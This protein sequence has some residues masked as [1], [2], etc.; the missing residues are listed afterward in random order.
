[1]KP[2]LVGM[3]LLAGVALAAEPISEDPWQALLAAR[4]N[5]AGEVSYA[6]IIRDERVRLERVLADLAAKNVASLERDHAIAFWLNAYHAMV[7]DAVMH[8]ERPTTMPGRAR[9]FHWYHRH[10]GGY[11]LTLDDVRFILNGFASQDPRIHLAIYDGTRSSPRLAPEPY[12]ADRLDAQL[13]AAARRF[14]NDSRNFRVN[15]AIGRVALS[16]VFEWYR[17]DF[18]RESGTLAGF[19]LPYADNQA[20]RAAL[21][22]PV[23]GF[24]SLPF[25]W[26][27]DGATE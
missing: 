16:K 12:R 22:S 1:M 17:A 5:Q 3:L 24:E 4:V 21:L 8:G 10:I 6:A 20:L 26:R 27:L 11:R 9:M 19:L 7:M 18:E 13:V 23:V 25:D 2:L 15:A 14:V